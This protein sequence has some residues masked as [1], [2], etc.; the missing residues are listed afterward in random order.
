MICEDKTAS[1]R[2]INVKECTPRN[3]INREIKSD[4]YQSS[5]VINRKDNY[6]NCKLK[7]NTELREHAKIQHYSNNSNINKNDNSNVMSQIDT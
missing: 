1:V 7:E 4:K 2:D 3:N 5:K 6:W